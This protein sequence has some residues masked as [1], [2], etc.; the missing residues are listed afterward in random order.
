MAAP[1]RC[2]YHR[3]SRTV[4][5]HSI[6]IIII[7]NPLERPHPPGGAVLGRPP[8][9][10]RARNGKSKACLRRGRERGRKEATAR[11]VGK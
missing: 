9:D 7:K 1:S 10:L 4:S 3:A 6:F 11:G 5:I 8:D 2:A